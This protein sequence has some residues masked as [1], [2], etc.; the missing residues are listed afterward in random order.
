MGLYHV[1]AGNHVGAKS[2]VERGVAGLEPFLPARD[3]LELL[4]LSARAR[5]CLVKT[6]R[7]LAG[8]TIEWEADDVPVM[9]LTG[10]E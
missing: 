3:G 7:A 5:R 1:A 9:R 2:L 10:V 6:E 8:E 4:E